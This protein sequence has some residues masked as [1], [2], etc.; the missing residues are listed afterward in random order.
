LHHLGRQ[1]L[2]DAHG[3]TDI[4]QVA[5]GSLTIER[6]LDRIEGVRLAP[7]GL[8]RFYA[9]CCKTPMGNTVGPKIPFVGIEAH[10]FDRPDDAFGPPTGGFLG[11]FAIGTPPP[12]STGLNVGLIV[13]AVA[14]FIGWRLRGKHWPH[15]YFDRATR[16]AVRPITVLSQ[17]DRDALRAHC[18]PRPAS[19]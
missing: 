12:G 2:L 18:G 1:E 10:A 14:T 7:K 11:K 19:A 15:P 5:P 6:G 13:R 8:Y 17:T 9:T 16:K 4:V 3:G